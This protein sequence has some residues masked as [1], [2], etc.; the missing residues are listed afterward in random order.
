MGVSLFYIREAVPWLNTAHQIH[1]ELMV[2]RLSA[3]G[4]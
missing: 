1:A 2:V 4:I 3:T